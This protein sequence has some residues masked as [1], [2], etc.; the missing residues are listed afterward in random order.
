MLSGMQ[1]LSTLHVSS[2]T[3]NVSELVLLRNVPFLLSSHIDDM[4][5]N[6]IQEVLQ[7]VHEIGIHIN[8]V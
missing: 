2:C 7:P 4:D 3:P 8:R 1:S 5:S 6:N